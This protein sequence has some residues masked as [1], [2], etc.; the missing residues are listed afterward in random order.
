LWLWEN[1]AHKILI[2]GNE[3]TF[4]LI[5]EKYS[6]YNPRK[7]VF[8]YPQITF[9]YLHF[10]GMSQYIS[11]TIPEKIAFMLIGLFMFL[12]ILRMT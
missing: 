8:Q 7:A 2:L 6:K 12:S 3:V 11:L 1:I 9:I 10:L 4:A 5:W